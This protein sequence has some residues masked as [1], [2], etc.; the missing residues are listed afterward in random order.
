MG[1][2]Q[3]LADW[4]ANRATSEQSWSILLWAENSRP[5]RTLRPSPTPTSQ[6]AWEIQ[7]RP[8]AS[9]SQTLSLRRY[10]PSRTL[11]ST[12]RSLSTVRSARPRRGSFSAYSETPK[13][14]GGPSVYRYPPRRTNR[15]GLRPGRL[16]MIRPWSLHKYRRSSEQ[17]PT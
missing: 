3:L 8:R 9:S 2:V 10:D 11:D 5:K 16:D 13:T 12:R 7:N 1:S 15:L 6:P 17:P 14:V 4:D